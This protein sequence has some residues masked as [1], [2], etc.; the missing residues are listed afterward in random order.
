M[1]LGQYLGGGHDAGLEAVVQGYEHGHQG[2]QRLAAA[3]VA[4]QQAVHLAPRAHVGPDLVHHA[5]LGPRQLEGQVL[6]VEV[7]EQR[8]NAVEHVAT[9]LPSLVAGIA[10]DVQLNEEQ[11]LELHPHAG[12]LQL[13]GVVRIVQRAQR[14]VAAHQVARS[15]DRVGQR[16]GQR[17]A[18]LF[19]QRPHQLLHGA[20]GH[21]RLLHLLRGVVVGLHL[22]P[23][24]LCLLAQFVQL[25]VDH[26][27]AVVEHGRAAEDDVHLSN[28]ILLHGGLAIV[29][30]HQV[31]HARAVAEVG[32]HA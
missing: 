31:H 5:L 6:L 13:L 11:L 18:Q 3:H 14:L 26:L 22:Y 25:G 15:Q 27:Y 1:L 7:V 20:A 17:L 12:A 21:A 16:L 24:R 4:L 23:L 10:Q 28:P 2:H 8:P 32:H 9:E 19:Q 29:E 30:P